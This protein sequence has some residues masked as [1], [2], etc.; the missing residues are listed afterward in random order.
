LGEIPPALVTLWKLNPLILPELSAWGH[1]TCVWSRQPFWR[2]I[3]IS[4]NPKHWCS[5]ANR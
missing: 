1:Q 2:F 5:S 4:E 3:F